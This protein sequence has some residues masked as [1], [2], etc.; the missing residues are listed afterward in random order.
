M[1]IKNFY[2]GVYV[3]DNL[4][5]GVDNPATKLHVDGDILLSNNK[6]L[7][8]FSSTGTQERIL[9]LNGS[10][11]LTLSGPGR[12]RVTTAGAARMD[13]F[14][15]HSTKYV[16][17]SVHSFTD[18]NSNV[19]LRIASSGRVGIKE[20]NPTQ[21]LHVAGNLRVTGAYYDS[22]NSTGSS[23]QVLSST[24]SGTD[25]ITPSSGTIG[26]SGTVNYIPKFTSTTAIGDSLAF[27]DSVGIDVDGR[28]I[29]DIVS[30]RN[31]TEFS[32]AKYFMVPMYRSE[33]VGLVDSK[34]VVKGISANEYG[35]NCTASNQLRG[36][37]RITARQSSTSTGGGI[38]I[39]NYETNSGGIP[40]GNGLGFVDSGEN[41]RTYFNLDTNDN[42]VVGNETPASLTT[43]SGGMIFKTGSNG[44][45]RATITKAGEMGIGV[46]TPRAK[47]DVDGGVKVANDTDSAAANKVGTLRYRYA[48]S[49]PKSQS[50]VDMCMQTGPSSYA[51]V[52]IVTNTWNN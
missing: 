51:W 45:T 29:A 38:L 46:T 23:G 32:D 22:N 33:S 17:S 34:I 44:D 40:G 11:L 4:G 25:W 10:D 1:A 27:Q 8:W 43:G 26:G 13:V 35:F 28:M 41:D 47:L 3:G 31:M 30:P 24:A 20:P 12:I 49:S 39:D 16:M 52:N 19:A 6:E 5:V 15:G 9:E 36:G 21:E 48:P 18:N 7:R 37:W 42:I 14:S 2:T 50:M